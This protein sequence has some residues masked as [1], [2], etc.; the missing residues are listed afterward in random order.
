MSIALFVSEK[1][2]SFWRFHR[3]DER[4][5]PASIVEQDA[6]EVE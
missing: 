3:Y 2:Q 1:Y 5:A 4:E 6:K